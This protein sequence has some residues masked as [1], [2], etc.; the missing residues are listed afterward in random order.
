MA[1]YMR[2]IE[3]KKNI[4]IPMMIYKRIRKMAKFI[5]RSSGVK[6]FLGLLFCTK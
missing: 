5:Y 3:I 1:C 6:V 2:Q 4:S